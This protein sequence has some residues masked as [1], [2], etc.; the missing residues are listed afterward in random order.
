V[1]TVSL[2]SPDGQTKINAVYERSL[3]KIS[4]TLGDAGLAELSNL[5]DEKLFEHSFIA[6][7]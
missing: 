7:F 4:F 1:T 6:A 5:A 3:R 2:P